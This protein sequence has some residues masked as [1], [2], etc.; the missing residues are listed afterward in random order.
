MKKQRLVA[1][2]AVFLVLFAGACGKDIAQQVAEQLELGQNYLL[3]QD[4]EQAMVAFNKAIEL[5][6]NTKEAYYGLGQSYE[7]LAERSGGD[8]SEERVSYYAKAEEAYRRVLSLDTQDRDACTRLIA[9]QLELGQNYLVVQDYEQAVVVFNKAIELEPNTKEAYYG[10]GQSYEELAER[11]GE[12]AAEERVSYYAKAEEAYRRV[13][14]LDSQDRDACARLIA[15]YE[16]LGEL[17]KMA[18]LG[19]DYYGEAVEEELLAQIREAEACLGV[20]QQLFALCEAGNTK[21]VFDVLQSEDYQ[22]L[23]E[24]SARLHSPAFLIKGGVGIGLYRVSTQKYGSNW[25]DNCMVYYGEFV[26]GM[27]QGHG[28]WFGYADG[29]TYYASGEW[30]GDL[31]NGKQ[32]V[33]EWYGLLNADVS[34]RVIRGT[35]VD[36]RWNGPVQWIFERKDDEVETFPVSFTN[37]RWDVLEVEEGEEGTKYRVSESVEFSNGEDGTLY[38][39]DPDTVEGIMGFLTD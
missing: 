39:S 5:E 9:I 26:D 6:P 24:L 28:L 13:L 14:F 34:T 31:P 16:N 4:Y 38:A 27:R 12:D 3:E 17:E 21:E 19:A 10:L 22:K 25:F 29:N 33:R 35:V 23:K 11:F 30:F 8:V 37:G 2:I 1:C 15:I 7:G 36:G 32:E 18:N 20:V